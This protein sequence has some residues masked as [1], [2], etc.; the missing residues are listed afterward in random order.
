LFCS[1]PVQL[2]GPDSRSILNRLKYPEPPVVLFTVFE[3]QE[4]A[5]IIPNPPKP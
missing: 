5:G 2:P 1:G 3:Y 4:P